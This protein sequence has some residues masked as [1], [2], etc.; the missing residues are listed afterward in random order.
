M[1][2]TPD[3]SAT[4]TQTDDAAILAEVRHWVE[5]LV[6]GENLCP[7]A[8]RELVKN[9][10]RFSL[11]EAVSEEELLTDLSQ[12]LALLEQEDRIET[13]LLIH[14]RLLNN[15]YD[16]NQFLDLA[17]A[18]LAEMDLEGVFQIA[19]F[20]PRY[21]FDGTLPDDVEN[22][23]NRSPYPMLHLL[24]ED[25][26]EQ[27]IADY[28]DVDAIPENNIRRLRELGLEGIRALLARSPAAPE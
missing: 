12:E 3:S 18:L 15:F 11:S 1:T 19:S 2:Q 26:L 7:F 25:S 23:T 24:R 17:D 8:K 10:V 22:Y 9:R 14:P 20:H 28:P 13:T 16:Y 5:A 4:P 6:V 27:R 21:Q